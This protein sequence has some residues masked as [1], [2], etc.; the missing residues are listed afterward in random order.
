MI[1]NISD[2]GR[3]KPYVRMTQKSKYT[4]PQAKEY[5]ASKKNLQTKFREFMNLHD[6]LMIEKGIPLRVHIIVGVLT[7]QGHSADVDNIL[8]AIMDA[9]NKIVFEDDRW[10]DEAWIIRRIGE[11]EFLDLGIERMA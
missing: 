1:I 7:S 8:K 4:N 6:I 2:V 11:K 5:L 10:V 9:C 3:I